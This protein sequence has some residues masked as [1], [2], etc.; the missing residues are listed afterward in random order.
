MKNF[1]GKICK[2]FKNYAE[3]LFEDHAYFAVSSLGHNPVDKKIS[4]NINPKRV[5]EPFLWLLFKLGYIE[6]KRK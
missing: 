4:F 3:S 5:C 1:L 2:P 6:G